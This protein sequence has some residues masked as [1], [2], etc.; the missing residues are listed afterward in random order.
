MIFY[1]RTR[2]VLDLV[3]SSQVSFRSCQIFG[4]F[5]SP[6]TRKK[7]SYP[8]SSPKKSHCFT[9]LL[10]ELGDTSPTNEAE[11]QNT[12]AS[13]TKL[14]EKGRNSETSTTRE[15]S[16]DIDVDDVDPQI[17]SFWFH[18]AWFKTCLENKEV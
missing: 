17:S 15:S 11:G 13:R 7:T 12:S 5:F 18:D 16:T 2:A 9:G 6:K 10:K 1:L 4:L 14:L 3:V 8:F